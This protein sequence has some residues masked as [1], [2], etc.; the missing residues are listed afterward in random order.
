M[1]QHA[2]HRYILNLLAT[3]LVLITS[4][5]SAN[6]V[7]DT[8]TVEDKTFEQ[9]EVFDAVIEAVH[10]STVSSRITAEVIEL[11]YDVNDIVPKDALIIKFRD[12]E[13]QARVAQIQA[14]L[15][16]N[17]AQIKEALARQK[18][19]FAEHNRIN[20][21]FVRQLA[22]QAS[23]DSTT[24]NLSAANAKL[25]VVKA[26]K[27]AQKAQ[28]NEAIV[29]LSYT[30]IIAPYA[31]VVTDRFI[32][33]GEMASPGQHLMVGMSLEQLRAIVKVPQYLLPTI[34][35]AK[36]PIINLIDGRNIA[37]TKVTIIPQANNFNHSFKV[38]VGLP[39]NVKNIY[40]G[41]FTKVNFTV[42][43]EIIRAIPQVAIV[44]QSEVSAVYVQAQDN[45]IYFR[46]VRLGRHLVGEQR[47]ILAGLTV[48][49][50]VLLDPLQA[51]KTL[52]SNRSGR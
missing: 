51:A 6:S 7:M 32:E 21:L 27:K 52:K 10:H 18:E 49:E 33:L 26:Q 4:V 47:E 39:E 50:Q 40:P 31:G 22:S 12:D 20:R 42:G 2:I 15:L 44:N 43:E 34:Q 48:G 19:A 41:L 11:N 25:L 29:Q 8:I 30:K 38:R 35:S 16:A 45:K 37:G 13:F 3:L 24:A 46:Q 23:L 28:L 17:D 36:A 14:S 1:K 9:H 5:S